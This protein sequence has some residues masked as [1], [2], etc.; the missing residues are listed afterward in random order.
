MVN[1]KDYGFRFYDPSIGRFTTV[2]PLTEKFA[3]QSG[4][5]FADNDPIGKID[6]MGVNGEN[7]KLT[8]YAGIGRPFF[9]YKHSP[10]QILIGGQE[11]WGSSKGFYGVLGVAGKLEFKGQVKITW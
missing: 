1:I 9:E 6:F 8:P 4:Y 10:N 2:D 7:S 3:H 11:D 5:V